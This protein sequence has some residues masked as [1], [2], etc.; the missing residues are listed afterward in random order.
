MKVYIQANRDNFPA[1]YNFYQ[2][3]LGFHE[4]G[5]ETVFFHTYE[6]LQKSSREDI[7]VGFV[8]AVRMRL[9]D[10]SITAPEMDYPD[11]LAGYLGRRVWHSHIETISSHP[12]MW[13]VFVKPVEDKKFTGVVV[14]S[15]R[16]LIGCGTEGEDPEVI[17][18]EVVR[19]IREWRVFV[20]YGRILDVRPYRGDWHVS[21]DA[22]TIERAVS[23]FRSAPA[24]Y[25]IDF[26]V[27]EDGRTLLLEVN[28]GYALGSYGLYYPEYA[29]LLSARWAELTGTEDACDFL[30]ERAGFHSAFR[31]K[32]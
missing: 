10:F 14:R 22:G 24:G 5:M 7:V 3:Y 20:R 31:E 30:N 18:S 13:P 21:Y 8:E 9:N 27:T 19:F 28:D 29:K 17:C 1:N 2:A 16:D 26:G 32:V 15:P 23:E 25:A 4:M 6:E 11:E 12:E